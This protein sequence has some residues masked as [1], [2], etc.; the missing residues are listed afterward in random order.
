M[1]DV[2]SVLCLF[3]KGKCVSDGLVAFGGYKDDLSSLMS[4]CVFVNI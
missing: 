1:T 3:E 2:V 4:L